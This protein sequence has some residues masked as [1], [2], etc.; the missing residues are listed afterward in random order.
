MNDASWNEA[1]SKNDSSSVEDEMIKAANA[2]HRAAKLLALK[3]SEKNESMNV[4]EGP[5]LLNG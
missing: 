1:W 5:Q 4:T 2:L 3:K